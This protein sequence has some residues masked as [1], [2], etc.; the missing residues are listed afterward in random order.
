VSAKPGLQFAV[1]HYRSYKLCNFPR[2]SHVN[3]V[4]ARS[5]SM[6]R[7]ASSFV[8]ACTL[9]FISWFWLRL[10]ILVRILI[11]GYFWRNIWTLHQII[12]YITLHGFDGEKWNFIYW[13]FVAPSFHEGVWE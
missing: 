2:H 5:S 3:K 4:E 7:E 6:L 8:F 11:F 12:F 10:F 9:Q 1:W 13:C